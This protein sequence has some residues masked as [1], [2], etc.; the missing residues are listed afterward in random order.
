MSRWY[1]AAICGLLAA[2]LYLPGLGGPALWEPDEGR[3]AEIAREMVISSDYVTP[4]VDWLPYF[5]KPPLVYW[6]NAASIRLFGSNEFAVRLPAALFTAGEVALASAIGE[7]MFGAEVGL[8]AALSL[9][10]SPLVFGFARFAMLDPALAFFLTAAAGAFYRAAGAP[11]FGR[12]AGRRWMLASA[13]MLALG[14]LAKGPVALVLGAAIALAWLIL[15]RRSRDIAR[16]PFVSCIAVYLAIVA[17]WFAIAE[18]RNPGF[19]RFFFV[20]EH[21]Q[22][23]LSSREHGWGPYFFVPVVAAGA[24]PWLFFVPAGINEVRSA[25]DESRAARLSALRYL[26]VWFAVI[27][28]FFSIPR[29]KLGS[30]ILPAMPPIAIIAGQGIASLAAAARARRLR[31]LRGFAIANVTLAVIAVAMLAR[32]FASENP[33]LAADG[34]LIAAAVAAGAVAAFALGTYAGSVR[35]ATVAIAIAMVIAMAAGER[36]RA[37]AA[38]L[39]TYRELARAIV[40]YLGE[41]CVV[42]SYRHYIQ[43]LPFYTGQRET[44]VEYWGELAEFEQPTAASPNF[45]GTESKLR[46][47]WRSGACVVLIANRKDLSALSKSLEPAPVA[48]ACEGKKVALINGALRGAARQNGCQNGS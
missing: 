41:R 31:W 25:A 34:M 39:A 48:I 32:M 9:A 43:S 14:T 46:D 2:L 15:E 37:D 13:A 29:S 11:D 19:L 5:E 20:H 17:P 12:G 26:A 42:A 4:R 10:L 47:L 7:A 38:G 35:A 24:W 6:C 36:A 44:V 40:P 33:A 8:L 28:I 30:Y 22:R 45:I 1:R 3:Y 27:F 16:I 18:M 21:L 23:F